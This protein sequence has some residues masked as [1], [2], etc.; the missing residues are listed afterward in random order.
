MG[1]MYFRRHIPQEKYGDDTESN[2]SLEKAFFNIYTAAT[3][4]HKNARAYLALL[5]ENGLIPSSEV[6]HEYTGP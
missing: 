3:L 6:I 1:K 2:E 4:G 5:I